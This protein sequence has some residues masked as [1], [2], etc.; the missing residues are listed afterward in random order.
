MASSTAPAAVPD[1]KAETQNA[2][3]T[4]AY[5]CELFECL[6]SLDEFKSFDFTP[7]IGR[8]FPD[9]YLTDILNDDQRIC[10]LAITV[11][12]RG[13]IFFRNQ[14]INSD[15][16]KVLGQ[17]L[18]ELSGKP[19]TSKLH[20]H[21][22][23]NTGRNLTV[24]EHGKLD[25]EISFISSETNRNYYGDRFRKNFKHLASE[26][27]HADITFERAP[28]DYAIPK[29]THSPED[30]AGGDTLWASGY[31][32]LADTLTAVHHQPSF[33]N[34]AKEHRIEIIEGDRGAPENTGFD[35]KARHP[36]VRTNPVTRW[37]IC[38][39]ITG[40]HGLQIRFKWGTNDLAIW[41]NYYMFGPRR[42]T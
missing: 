27:W 16:Q 25:E 33:K 37:K 38:R 8:E 32:A 30:Q 12:R 18:G 19:E 41:D 13:V 29:I 14:S 21:A 20:R 17:K 22:T 34:I 15:E 7:I 42:R 11:S 6:G 40:N 23:N 39:L 24:N 1:T 10:D 9:V 26:G 36:L 4:S 31:E 3:A 28:S 5:I 35:F 2:A